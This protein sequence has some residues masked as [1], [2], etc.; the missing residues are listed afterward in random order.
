MFTVPF[1]AAHCTSRPIEFR[2]YLIPEKTMIMS[3]M[4]EA[5]F[6]EA[7]YP[8]AKAFLPERWLN[9]DLTRVKA[10]VP[11][12]YMP[13]GIGYLIIITNVLI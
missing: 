6:N 11:K 2:G 8:D 12:S 4:T 9:Q 13:F 5:L 3:N 7:D 1:G 10:D